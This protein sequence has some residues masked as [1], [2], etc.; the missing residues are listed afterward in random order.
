MKFLLARDLHFR[1]QQWDVEF[2][3]L[4]FTLT[5]LTDIPG[6]GGL[7]ADNPGEAAA[8]QLPLSPRGDPFRP[9]PLKIRTDGH[10]SAIAAEC[11][12]RQELQNQPAEP[13]ELSGQRRTLSPRRLPLTRGT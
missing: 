3:M 8:E 7:I 2:E 12:A 11:P 4:W 6:K 13:A 1:K 9:W 10:K 5:M